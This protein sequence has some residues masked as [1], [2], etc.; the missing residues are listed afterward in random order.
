MTLALDEF[1]RRFL[2]HVLPA[3][4]SAFATTAS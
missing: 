2:L 3:A 1:L 4:S